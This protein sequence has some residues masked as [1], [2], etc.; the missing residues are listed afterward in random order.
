MNQTII[1]LTPKAWTLLTDTDVTRLTFQARGGAIEIRFT[2]DTTEP[3]YNVA[4]MIYRDDTGETMK[5]ISE[6]VSDTSHVRAWARA[7]DGAADIFVDHA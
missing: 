2:T 1:P 5:L 6:L 7:V 4:G 3:D